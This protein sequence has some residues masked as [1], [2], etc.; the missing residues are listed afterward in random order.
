MSKTNKT[1]AK[2]VVISHSLKYNNY[3][4]I[5]FSVKGYFL[6]GVR[7]LKLYILPNMQ[8]IS[9]AGKIYIGIEPLIYIEKG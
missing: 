5:T 6:S 3:G 2:C 9:V 1:T 4:Y 8:K 7:N